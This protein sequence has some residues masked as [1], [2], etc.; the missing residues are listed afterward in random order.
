MESLFHLIVYV[1]VAGLI[2]YLVY[3]LLGRIPM[4]APF[5]VVAEVILAVIAILFLLSLLFGGGLHFAR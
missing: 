5:K 4:P 3:W 2:F 1:I